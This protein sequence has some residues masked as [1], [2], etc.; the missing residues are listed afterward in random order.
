MKYIKPK[1]LVYDLLFWQEGLYNLYYRFIATLHGI[2]PLLHECIASSVVQQRRVNSY[3]GLHYHEFSDITRQRLEVI[4]SKGMDSLSP[5]RFYNSQYNSYTAPISILSTRSFRGVIL[6]GPDMLECKRKLNNV[7]C[8]GNDDEIKEI[9]HHFVEAIVT[10]QLW[11]RALKIAGLA[12]QHHSSLAVDS[13][14]RLHRVFRII[15]VSELKIARANRLQILAVKISFIESILDDVF[16]NAMDRCMLI[17]DIFLR[18]VSFSDSIRCS[19]LSF[20]PTIGWREKVEDLSKGSNIKSSLTDMASRF[21]MFGTGKKTQDTSTSGPH[22]LSTAVST[23]RLSLNNINNADHHR[24][25]DHDKMQTSV[26][27]KLLNMFSTNK[28]K[29]GS[30]G[31]GTDDI[32]NQHSA[33]RR[34][35]ISYQ[36]KI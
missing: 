8:D 35:N 11:Y 2:A 14:E 9:E 16:S 12:M 33:H 26:T 29:R 18:N 13:H 20:A 7:L 34:Q 17:D 15:A 32:D 25:G 24:L 19:S 23:K 30:V 1:V 4:C 6:R 27:A 28:G 3:I 31:N 10:V 22:L 36:K 21:G 5:T